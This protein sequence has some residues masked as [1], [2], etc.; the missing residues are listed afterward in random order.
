MYL[1]PLDKQLLKVMIKA[2][3]T[4]Q[5]YVIVDGANKVLY[6][7]TG[8]E[9]NY[10]NSAL[11]DG[12]NKYPLDMEPYEIEY[13]LNHLLETDLVTHGNTTSPALKVTYMGW[14]N[15]QLEKTD[16]LH[17]LLTNLFFPALV[18]FITALLTVLIS[19]I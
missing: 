3:Q 14:Y 5:D 15:E 2:Q 1:T 8:W 17:L 4:L 10:V 6:H 13:A 7:A 18:S 11:S 12:K 16:A 19:K 9:H